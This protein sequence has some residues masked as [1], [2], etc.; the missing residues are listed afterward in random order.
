M[1]NFFIKY[2]FFENE[3]KLLINLFQIIEK[4]FNKLILN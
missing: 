1:N 4:I 3:W 2:L